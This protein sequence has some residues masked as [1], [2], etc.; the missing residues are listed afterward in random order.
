MT[1]PF[2][3]AVFLASLGAAATTLVLVVLPGTRTRAID[4]YVL[5]LG[6]VILF[7][8]VRVTAEDG[9]QR[10]S[11]LDRVQGE[12]RAAGRL[13]ELARIEREVFLATARELRR[14][15]QLNSLLRDIARHQLWTRRGIDLDREPDRAR[16]VLGN[17]AW[18]VIAPDATS[19]EDDVVPPLEL[20]RL[21]SVVDTLE[22]V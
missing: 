2:R 15:R 10:K 7:A 1:R 12:R 5:F 16:D 3:R 6:A 14:V 20:A 8:L 22:R 9:P 19:P 21:R 17:D 4:L 13:P 11:A 18:D